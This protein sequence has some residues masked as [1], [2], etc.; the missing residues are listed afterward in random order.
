MNSNEA[1]WAMVKAL[2]EAAI[3][4]MLVG[5]F[6]SNL[7]GVARSTKDADFVVQCRGSDVAAMVRRL[8]V[9]FRLDPQVTFESVTA[10]TRYIVTLD[11]NPFRIEFFL[12]SDDPHDRERFR[13][14]RPVSHPGLQRTAHVPT[15]ED[16]IV[17]KLRWALHAQRGKDRDDVRDVIAVQGEALDWGYIQRWCDEHGTRELL[18]EIRRELPPLDEP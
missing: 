16:V 9:P 4:Y 13:R 14:R 17:T 2:E 10:T 5:S 18:E 3:P 1:T 7:Y 15:A 11:E 8:G 12:L 6:S